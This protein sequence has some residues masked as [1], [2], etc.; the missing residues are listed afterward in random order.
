MNTKHVLMVV[1]SPAVSTTV[2]GPVGFWASEMTHPLWE[3]TEAGYS[4][5][6]AS[7]KG[8]TVMVDQLSDPQQLLRVFF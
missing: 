1:A 2:G 4:I 3:F 8:G 6:L 5:D 7:P